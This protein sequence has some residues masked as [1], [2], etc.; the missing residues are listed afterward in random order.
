MWAKFY[1]RVFIIMDLTVSL[2]KFTNLEVFFVRTLKIR[3]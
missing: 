1:F 3:R 2:G